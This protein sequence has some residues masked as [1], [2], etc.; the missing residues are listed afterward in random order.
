MKS[1]RL[2][3]H[4]VDTSIVYRASGPFTSPEGI[5]DLTMVGWV[6]LFSIHGYRETD[7]DGLEDGFERIAIYGKSP[8]RPEHLARQKASGVWVSKLGKGKD[9]EHTAGSTLLPIRM[10][11]S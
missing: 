5:S 7:N 6:K 8:D 10:I 11:L 2:G 3:A 1:V 4:R 9:I